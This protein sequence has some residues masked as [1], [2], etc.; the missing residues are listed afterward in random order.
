[1]QFVTDKNGF[2]EVRLESIG[3][4]GA[5]SAGQMLAEI[6]V[7]GS[8][9]HAICFADYG[10]EKKGA[11]VKTFIRFAPN[12]TKILNYSP[13]ESPKIVAVFHELLFLTQPVLSGLD[14]EGIVIVNSSRTPDEIREEF[15]LPNRYIA[16]V[17]ATSIAL[18]LKTKLN[19]AMLGGIFKMLE[20]L[21]PELA[22][23]SIEK[24]FGYK[25]PHLVGPNIETFERGMKE[26][27]VGEYTPMTGETTTKAPTGF[28]YENQVLGG[29]I[30]GPNTMT[31]NL[32]A[33]REGML[34][35]WIEDKCI[36]CA[37]CDTVCPDFCFVWEKGE[38]KRGREQMF[39]R[40]IDY[41]H[42]KGCLKCI[43]VCPTSALQDM[44]ETRGYA[45]AHR[46]VKQ[47][48]YLGGKR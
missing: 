35:E 46:M 14:S 4:Q 47:Y 2:F 44:I 3:G 21:K 29:T 39:L 25:Y 12:T 36:H 22:A 27:Q 23:A 9:L 8:D 31:K 16:T 32:T 15:N 19:T 26:L 20:F 24:Q 17:D 45:D 34:P 42:C 33:S 48:P 11:P 38:D 13:V 30:L 41:N 10:S 1:M 5:Y 43:Q 6:G 40:G 7:Q 37:K 28:G 18:E